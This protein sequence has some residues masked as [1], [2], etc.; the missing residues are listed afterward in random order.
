MPDVRPRRW[1]TELPLI[2]V[3]YVAY[4]CARLLARGDVD[5]AL[6]NGLAILRLER[7]FFLNA[8][9]PLNRIFTEHAALG[10]PASFVYASLHYVVTPAILVWLFRS[11]PV[12][13][14]AMRTWLMLSTLLG[15][16][17]FTLLPTAPPRLLDAGHG[18]VDSLAQYSGYGWWS[19]AASAPSGLGD[20]TNQYAAMPSLHVGWALWCGVVLWW[21]DRR[22]VPVRIAAV[23][24]PLLTTVVVMGTA[25]HYLLDVLGGVLVM[26]LGLLLTGP[27][28]R[29]A[30]RVR[31]R[32]AAILPRQAVPDSAAEGH[33][34]A[35]YP[36][37]AHA[38]EGTGDRER[39]RVSVAPGA[40]PSAG[41][42]AS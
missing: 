6:D 19:D 18:F 10:V 11:R 24:Y 35:A 40:P 41:G 7:T 21:F 17:G 8:E 42:G 28:L 34:G 29:L 33:N 37:S 38:R 31:P 32:A 12:R 14:R 13:Y 25:N 16:V 5:T 26:G 20:M 15:L 36:T 22:S 23:G 9:E 4:S 2:L 3:V 1:W 30:D 27:A 39:E